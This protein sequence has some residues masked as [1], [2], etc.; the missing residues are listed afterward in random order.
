MMDWEKYRDLFPV[1]KEQTYFMTAGGGAIPT[2][3]RDAIVNRYIAVSK[4]GGREFGKN[5]EI[6][7]QCRSKLGKLINADAENIAF[8]PSVSFGMNALAHSLPKSGSI[9][10][11]ADEFPASVLPW[12]NAGHD[13][14]KIPELSKREFALPEYI[15]REKE[16]ISTV[17][18]SYIHYAHGYKI[19]L[20]RIRKSCSE[21]N[22]VVNGTQAIGAFPLDLKTQAM[23]AL[24][25]SCYKWMFCGEGIA[26]MYVNPQFFA[27]LHPALVGWRS[28][29]SSMQF[30]GSCQ[31]FPSAKVFELGWDNMTIFSGFSAALD[32][33][34][35]I[36]LNH[37]T[38]RIQQLVSYLVDGLKKTDMPVISDLNPDCRSGTVLLGP[39][40]ELQKVATFLEEKNIW[41][42]LRGNGIRIS[43]HFYN[44]EEDIDRLLKALKEVSAQLGKTMLSDKEQAEGLVS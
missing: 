16:A 5:I 36:G 35:E 41:T 7:E 43:I 10:A 39:F 34:E 15:E 19:P 37:I 6:M 23:D 3:V 1:V 14:K 22:L 20:D 30:D 12:V 4:G 11:V 29:E 33:L 25:C 38:T 18:L 26:F 28:V 24:I 42:T 17:V 8:I 9:L 40:D 32:L 2:P 21:R 13:L 31:Y 44:N 27:K